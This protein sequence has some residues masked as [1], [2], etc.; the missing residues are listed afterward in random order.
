[1]NSSNRSAMNTALK[2]LMTEARPI[3][4]NDFFKW[5][6]LIQGPSDTPFEGGVFEAELSFPRDYP[7]SPPKVRAQPSPERCNDASSLKSDHAPGTDVARN[8]LDPLPRS[9]RM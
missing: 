7:L 5:S 6:A 4:E 2:R 9:R 8:H 1:M 3:S